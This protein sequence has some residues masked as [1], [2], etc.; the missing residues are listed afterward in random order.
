MLSMA[1]PSSLPVTVTGVHARS[2]LWLPVRHWQP[3]PVS[4]SN[5]S[6]YSRADAD[7]LPLLMNSIKLLCCYY[8][9][10]PSESDSDPSPDSSD[11][12]GDPV[13]R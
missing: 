10:S 2:R 13:T 5:N 12:H 7:Y 1:G 3:I 11:Y 6:Y 9:G 4:L 8:P